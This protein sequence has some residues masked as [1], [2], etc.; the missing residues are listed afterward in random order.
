MLHS[1]RPV[2]RFS[3]GFTV[4]LQLNVFLRL[5]PA[6]PPKAPRLRRTPQAK[7][8]LPGWLERASREAFLPQKL[9][10]VMRSVE[11]RVAATAAHTPIPFPGAARNVRI[12]L[13]E[14]RTCSLW[15]YRLKVRTEPSQGS[16]PGSSPGIATNPQ[17]Q[18][19]TA[20]VVTRS[21]PEL[22]VLLGSQYQIL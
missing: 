7:L 1:S 5:H 8:T 2:R 21:F 9:F 19:I 13:A 16:N 10:Q 11:A 22:T 4:L 12:A 3:N 18:R 20:S 6:W 14:V 15:R 17:N